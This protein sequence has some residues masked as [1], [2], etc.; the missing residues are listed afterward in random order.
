AY[1]DDA[2]QCAVPA[3][4]PSRQDVPGEAE[5]DPVTPT[6]YQFSNLRFLSTAEYQGTSM[7]GELVYTQ[8]D[9]RLELEMSALWPGDVSCES[10]EDCSPENQVNAA[11]DTFCSPEGRCL[12]RNPFPSLKR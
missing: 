10:D 9:C 4:T 3:L 1:V 6:T 12:M 7:G 11:Y 2:G 5:A 8:G